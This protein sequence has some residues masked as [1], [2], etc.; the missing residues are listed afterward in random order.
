MTTPRT[1]LGIDPGSRNAGWG[2]VTDQSGV[3]R[4]VA[5]GV[6]HPKGADF[7][8]RLGNL[9]TELARIVKEY[10]PDEAAIEDVHAAQNVATALKLGQARG[11]A[12]GACAAFGIAVFD[13]RP[14]VIKKALVGTGRAE[15]EQVA[16]MVAHMLGVKQANWAL[17]TS[18]ALG[19]AICHCNHMRMEKLLKR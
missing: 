16:Y 13:Y 7:S 15:K 5:C 18:D 2:V 12:V 17:D 3:L 4:L 11:I 19:A 9:Y 6:I 8:A 14:T 10:K 1:V